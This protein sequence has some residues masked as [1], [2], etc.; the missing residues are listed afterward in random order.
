MAAGLWAGTALLAG[1]LAA[2]GPIR[3]LALVLLVAG[4]LA[5]YGAAALMLGAADRADLAR[6]L[7]RRF[8]R[9][10]PGA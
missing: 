5:L 4:G 8:R 9:P 3:W 1:W 2:Q 7:P 6:L 10:V